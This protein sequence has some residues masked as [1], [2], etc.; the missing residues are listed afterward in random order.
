MDPIIE[1]ADEVRRVLDAGSFRL[2]FTAKRGYDFLYEL[3]ALR[4]LK[5]LVMP[6]SEQ[7]ALG[8]RDGV[9]EELQIDVAVVAKLDGEPGDIVDVARCDELSQLGS[10]IKQHL[11]DTGTL[12]GHAWQG[13]QR[14]AL[15]DP[16]R[17]REEHV[18]VSLQTHEYLRGRFVG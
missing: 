7:T 18:F 6:R 15:W 17:L 14:S 2:P 1:L 13:C 4:E 9:S 10:E 12:L 5:V 8:S 11:L 3:E 16:K